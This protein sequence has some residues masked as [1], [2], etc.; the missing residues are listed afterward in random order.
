MKKF[1]SV[2]I[3]LTLLAGLLVSGMTFAYAE[4]DEADYVRFTATGND[5]YATFKFSAEG[6]HATIDPDTV[7][8]AAIR[9]RTISEVDNTGVPFKGQLYVSPAAE[10]FVPITYNFSKNWETAIIDCTS[11]AQSTTLDSI[12]DSESY[13]NTSTIRFD[14]L[15][16]DR[17][18]L[19]F[20]QIILGKKL[21]RVIDIQFVACIG[22][23]LLLPLLRHGQTNHLDANGYYCNPEYCIY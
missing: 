13:K 8:W 20:G 23:R 18:F 21:R 6:K 10:P 9:Y 4:E 16:S 3:S 1:L 5:P 7:K 2:L 22:L 11:V 17:D 15:E 14:P 19:Q 12:W